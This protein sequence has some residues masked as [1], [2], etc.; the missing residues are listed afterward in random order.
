MGKIRRKTAQIKKSPL[1]VSKTIQAGDD[2]LPD[3]Q[4]VKSQSTRRKQPPGCFPVK[5][6]QPVIR[7]N[8]GQPARGPTRV[9]HLDQAFEQLRKIFLVSA[10]HPRRP[11]LLRPPPAMVEF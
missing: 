6:F 3:A 5:I 11:Q 2:A 9:M 1:P 8:A 7:E 4:A 10:F